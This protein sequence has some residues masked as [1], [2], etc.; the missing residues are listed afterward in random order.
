MHNINFTK[1]TLE[2]FNYKYK[3]QIT[4]KE[5]SLGNFFDFLTEELNNTKS[6]SFF[7]SLDADDVIQDYYEVLQGKYS[8]VEFIEVNGVYLVVY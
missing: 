6:L 8:M 3:L 1:M 2:E 5:S 7:S 4:H